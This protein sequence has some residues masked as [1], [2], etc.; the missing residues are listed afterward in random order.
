MTGSP[1]RV[2]IMGESSTVHV[3][4]ATGPRSGMTYSRWLEALLPEAG[5]DVVVRNVGREGQR[6]RDAVCQWTTTEH[7][8]SPDVVILKLGTYDCLHTVLPHAL[9]RAMNGRHSH[10][11]RP[12]EA[13]RAVA[14]SAWRRAGRVQQR[15]DEHPHAVLAH[16][17]RRAQREL[18]HLINLI[19]AVHHP[20]ILVVSTGPLGD[21]WLGWFPG[22]AT[23]M[24]D[25]DAAIETWI[26]TDGDPDI[27]YIPANEALGWSPRE[28]ERLPTEIAPDG[29]H[30]SAASH[31]VFAESLVRVIV[32]WASTQPHLGAYPS[33]G[34]PSPADFAG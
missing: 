4:P 27:R 17:A 26:R 29:A 34:A 3:A 21:P 1:L 32:P 23:R 15:V 30:Y 19:R 31:R 20:L 7:L 28:G 10:T 14:R 9:E 22:A 13:I 2:L 24:A 12:R 33:S 11:G 16:R 25:L 6:V 5:V 8:W 18:V